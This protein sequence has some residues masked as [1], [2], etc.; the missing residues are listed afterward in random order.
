[1]S[2]LR[3][4]ILERRKQFRVW[5]QPKTCEKRCLFTGQE[6]CGICLPYG[7]SEKQRKMFIEKLEERPHLHPLDIF[8]FDGANRAGKTATAVARTIQ[9]LLEY[10]GS[11]ALVGAA[12]LPILERSA[13]EEWRKRFSIQGDWDHPLVLR[14]PTAQTKCLRLKNGSK[15]WFI[16]FSDYQILR[17]VEADIIHIE[18]ASL[19]PSEDSMNE[20]VRRLSGSKGPIKQLILTTN[21]EESKGW[22]YEKFSLKQNEPGYDG[23]TLPIGDT[24]SCN[25]C[26]PCLNIRKEKVEF[27]DG[28]CPKCNAAKE[29]NCPG[30]Q[31]FFRVLRVASWD[32]SHLPSDYVDNMRSSMS[33]EYF[34]LYGEG[35]LV[36]LRKGK[37]YK[38]FSKHNIHPVDIELDYGKPLIWSFDFNVSYQCSVVCQERQTKLGTIVDVIDEIVVPEAGPE[39]VAR[40]F[41]SRYGDY[42]GPIIIYGDPSALNNKTGSNDPSQFQVV[43]EILTNPKKAGMD[44]ISPKKVEVTVK[45]IK[46]QTKIYVVSRVES[47]NSMLKNASGEIRLYLNPKCR[48]TILSLED[49]RWMENQN[50]TSQMDTRCDKLAAKSPNKRVLHLLSHPTDAL[51]YYIYK[52][53][54]IVPKNEMPTF[55]QV[56]GDRILEY[57]NHN[58][59]EYNPYYPDPP[60]EA[61][62]EPQSLME[63]L[64]YLNEDTTQE[65]DLPWFWG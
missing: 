52:K 25:V 42:N 48:Y 59:K 18:E 40:E 29:N 54:P 57:D 34:Q 11:T 7:P 50:N 26:S 56:P 53:F 13:K 22:I 23:P 39:Q 4:E 32:N 19:L 49:M 16:H 15:A 12:N 24:C 5:P 45:K 8:L 21:P 51:G 35:K 64:N 41:L 58:I 44:D 36:E 9:Y 47:T 27:V 2:R 63:L 17:G 62:R 14:K 60:P 3:D 46:G 20:L 30:D 43:Y 1:M 61:K 37:I 55:V 6:S 65:G 10:P 31:E 38:S 33:E 28:R